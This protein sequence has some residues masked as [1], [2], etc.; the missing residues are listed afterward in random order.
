MI[1]KRI[2]RGDILEVPTYFFSERDYVIES[3]RTYT[4]IFMREIYNRM[5]RLYQE[6]QSLCTV[7]VSYSKVLAA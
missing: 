1:Y 5:W 2:E 3:Q 7:E 4:D 6:I